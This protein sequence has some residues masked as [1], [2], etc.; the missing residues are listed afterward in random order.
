MYIYDCTAMV[1]KFDIIMW[2]DAGYAAPLY[3]DLPL[4]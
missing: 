1:D 3:Q 4:W 2:T